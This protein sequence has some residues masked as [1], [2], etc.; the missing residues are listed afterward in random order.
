MTVA[1][2]MLLRD[3][4]PY[5]II[6]VCLLLEDVPSYLTGGLL[7]EYKRNLTSLIIAFLG[8]L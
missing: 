2:V 8:T 1:M 6:S 4:V 7:V 3:S 5:G